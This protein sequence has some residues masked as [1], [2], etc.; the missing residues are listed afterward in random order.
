MLAIALERLRDPGGDPGGQ[1]IF[2]QIAG[3][4]DVR[5]HPFGLML[6]FNGS[7]GESRT[8]SASPS[9]RGAVVA[10]VHLREQGK[11]AGV[12]ENYREIWGNGSGESSAAQLLVWVFLA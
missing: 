5:V 2:T 3:S 10:F 4:G 11:D 8:R 1:Y 9:S 6:E 7:I 12:L